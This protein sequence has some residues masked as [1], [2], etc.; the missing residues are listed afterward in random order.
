MSPLEDLS[1]LLQDTTDPQKVLFTG[2]RGSGKSTE[3]AKLTQGLREQFFIIHYSIKSILNLFDL[4]YVDVVLSL[5]LELIREATAQKVK[6]NEEVLR[7]ILDFTKEITREVETGVKE[8]AEV[9]DVAG[10]VNL[11]REE[12]AKVPHAVIFWVREH[13]LREIATLAPD[14]WAWRSGVFDFRSERFELPITAVQNALAEP[15]VFKDRADLDRRISLYQGLIQEYSQQEKPDESFLAR[16]QVKLASAFYLLGNFKEAETCLR[17]AL[18][19]S[20]LVGDRRMEADAFRKLGIL[21]QER[22]RLDEAEEKYRQSLSIFEQIGDDAGIASIHHQLGN[23][24]YLWQEFD[25]AEQWYRKALKIF[26]RLGLERYAAFDY[27][28]LGIIA[29]ER[30]ESDNAEEWYR[31]ALEIRE[32]LGLERDAAD[33]YHQLGNVALERHQFDNAEEWYRKALEIFERLGHP[34]LMVNTLTQFGTLRWRQNRLHEAV[35]WLGKAFV[36]AA[37][38]NM[39]VGGQILMYLARVMNA[40]GEEEFTAAWRQ[41]FEGQEPPLELIRE[42]IGKSERDLRS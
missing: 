6:V 11:Q 4:N 40:M 34:P 25:E 32:R 15:L 19:R 18:E 7:H 41:A 39:R 42:V 14:F 31:K 30:Q 1:I 36:I 28:Q 3:L 21:A 27:H 20:R 33:T 29:Q 37:E 17:E 10:Y 8:Q 23:I 13:G 5:G 24:A 26:E 38:Y 22:W 9:G 16:L 12:F 2:H 35:S